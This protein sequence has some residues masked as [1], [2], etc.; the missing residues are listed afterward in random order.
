MPSHVYA[1][2]GLDALVI[3][4]IFCVLPTIEAETVQRTPIRLGCEAPGPAPGP[5]DRVGAE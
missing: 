2:S 1:S 3:W 5:F 4:G